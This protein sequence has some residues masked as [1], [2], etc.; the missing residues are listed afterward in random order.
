MLIGLAL[1]LP[2][3]FISTI[4]DQQFP[5]FEGRLALIY[6]LVYIPARWI[7]WS[8]TA[9]IL[10]PR[11]RTLDAVVAGVNSKDLQWRGLGVAVSCGLDVLLIGA[12]GMLPVGKFY[13]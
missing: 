3:Y 5:P 6:I 2:I 12:F 7:A 4:L 1:A 11:A 10:N 8:L 9:P 13:C